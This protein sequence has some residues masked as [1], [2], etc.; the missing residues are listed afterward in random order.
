M[1]TLK[2]RSFLPAKT[3]GDVRTDPV[4]SMTTSINR[5][6]FVVEDLGRIIQKMHMDKM[7][8]LDDQK[9]QRKLTRDRQRESK[10]EADVSK[11]M[12][13]EDK[14]GNNVLRKTGGL[15][16]NLLSPF[17]WI[18]TKLL[19][20]LALNWMS[21]PKN[22]K[23]IKTVLPWIGKWLK[24]FWKVLSTGV[25]WILEA[26]SENSPVMGALKIIGGISALFLADR[27]LQPWKLI[28]D[29]NRLRKLI[30]V[31]GKNA[32]KNSATQQLTKK[33]IAKQRLQNINKIK[34]KKLRAKRMLRMKRLTKVKAGRF[35]KGGGLSVV[36]GLV[37]FGTRMSQGDSLQKAAGGGIGAAIGG[38]ALTAFLTPILGPFAPIVGNIVG[39]FL[40]DKIGAFIGDAITPIIKPIKDY[41]VSIFLPGFKAFLEPFRETIAEYIKTVVPVIQMVW[42]KISPLMSSAVKGYTDYL[43]NGPVGKAIESLIWLISTGSKILGGLITNI[44]NFAGGTVN[45]YQRIFSTGDDKIQAQTENEAFDVKRLKEQLAQFKKDREEKGGDKRW[46]SVGVDGVPRTS[47]GAAGMGMWNGHW[48][49]LGSTIDEKIKHWEE[50]LIPHAEKQLLESQSKKVSE[51]GIQPK[52]NF[53]IFPAAAAAE[54]TNHIVTSK[55]M[56]MRWGK[57]HKGVDIATEIGEKLHSFMDGVVQ[58][59][60]YDKGYGNY[61]AFTTRDGIGQFYAHMDKMSKLKDGQKLRAGQVVGEAGNSGRSTG[62]H[63][64]WETSTN[65]KDVGYGGP[66]IFDPLTK[67]GKESPFTGRLEPVSDY[68]VGG[69]GK[70]GKLNS[71]LKQRSEAESSAQLRGDVT[72]T[73]FIVQPVLRDFIQTGGGDQIVPVNRPVKDI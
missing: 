14:K 28:G 64:H 5:L 9:D 57:I 61:I 8:W 26:F 32:T 38:V 63:L 69:T 65:P 62:P 66:S 22:T 53:S 55:A 27:I 48:N 72:N 45:T 43:V 39:G 59:V 49:P 47:N 17:I 18:G 36:G 35:M 10:I 2:I 29:A 60:G 58:N 71:E 21:D 6:G 73:L 46:I 3:T 11:E 42:R 34:A 15:L 37:S 30:S 54:M 31:D 56:T 23:L 20:F 25:N 4:A 70:G 12:D 24:T 67:Y 16:Q 51:G 68:V 1:A 52:S 50:V 44:A 19:G 40:G 33:Q 13:R 41:F 7:E